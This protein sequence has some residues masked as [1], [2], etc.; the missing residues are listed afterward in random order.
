MM[1]NAR[2]S[3]LAFCI[4]IVTKHLSKCFSFLVLFSPAK[5][6][7]CHEAINEAIKFKGN[8]LVGEN[9]EKKKG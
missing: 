7:I 1:Q 5:W 8:E 4:F 6:L 3:S 2:Q 9:A